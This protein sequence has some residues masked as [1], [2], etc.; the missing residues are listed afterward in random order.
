MNNN[1]QCGHKDLTRL[2][3]TELDIPYK[4]KD[5]AC[6]NYHMLVQVEHGTVYGFGSNRGGRLGLPKIE[7]KNNYLRKIYKNV[8]RVTCGPNCS[9]IITK[10]GSLYACGESRE[11]I[12]G[13][14]SGPLYE[15]MLIMECVESVAHGCISFSCKNHG[16]ELLGLGDNQHGQVGEDETCKN[17]TKPKKLELR[18]HVAE[19]IVAF[20]CGWGFSYLVDKDGAVHIVGVVY[21]YPLGQGICVVPE[22]RV[23]GPIPENF[24]FLER[25]WKFVYEPASLRNLV[26][27]YVELWF[28][29][30]KYSV[31]MITHQ[32]RKMY[33]DFLWGILLQVCSLLLP[34]LSLLTLP[35]TLPPPPHP[36]T[37][38]PPPLPLP[39][40][41][42]SSTPLPLIITP[43]L[44]RRMRMGHIPFFHVLNTTLVLL[45]CLRCGAHPLAQR[46]QIEPKIVPIWEWV[47]N[48]IVSRL[49]YRHSNGTTMTRMLNQE[50]EV[51]TKGGEE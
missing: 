13:I 25:K 1:R 32:R 17:V 30:T 26:N 4:V 47:R 18:D 15:M 35:P 24:I 10:E 9:M 42:P 20:G 33:L 48:S 6:G 19:S 29:Q 49:L 5:V 39:L 51:I 22:L 23:S 3:P 31:E 21:R 41:L 38:T 34:L 45:T 36:S 37:F 28:G 11:G 8:S 44:S 7:K 14:N 2:P 27:I 16:W 50:T 40:P 43:Y 12:L 46:A